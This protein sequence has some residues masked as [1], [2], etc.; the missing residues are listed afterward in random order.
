[1]GDLLATGR[2]TEYIAQRVTRSGWVGKRKGR[3]AQS[4]FR[5]SAWPSATNSE[6]TNKLSASRTPRSLTSF[7]PPTSR[8]W[9]VYRICDPSSTRP[10]WSA[11]KWCIEAL[12][13]SSKYLSSSFD[14]SHIYS[15]SRSFPARRYRPASPLHPPSG[16]YLS[17]STTPALSALG[18][19]QIVALVLILVVQHGDQPT[20][21]SESA[22]PG[23]PSRT[24]S[25]PITP[26]AF[27][28]RYSSQILW[29]PVVTARL[30]PC[31]IHGPRRG[32]WR[33]RLR[34]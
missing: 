32:V 24:S 29:S 9:V 5:V 15:L 12:G 19:R 17:S 2:G 7:E 33:R 20:R 8:E 10:F 4:L 31:Q 26:S 13:T 6:Q 1:M 34:L 3:D 28:A 22:T 27:K 14:V 23:V 21:S 25:I 18:E 30:R 16:R 11:S